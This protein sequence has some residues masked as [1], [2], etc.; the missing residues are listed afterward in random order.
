[1]P[2][3]TL[4]SS[5]GDGAHGVGMASV[6]DGWYRV[7]AT[8]T[9]RSGA[10]LPAGEIRLG[11]RPDTT[12]TTGTVFAW[13]A[14]FER[15]DPSA[16]GDTPAPSAY[17]PNG[18]PVVALS[19]TPVRRL[20]IYPTPTLNTD[21][22]FIVDYRA[23]WLPIVA[24]TDMIPVPSWADALLLE[25]CRAAARGAYEE[26]DAFTFERYA[27]LCASPTFQKYTEYDQGQQRS[28]G[29]MR[30][31]LDGYVGRDWRTGAHV[32]GP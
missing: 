25:F 20:A 2:V 8:I 31:I 5:Q 23:S 9:L 1:M 28:Y 27:A 3:V 17:S 7:W 18:G 12:G 26:D 32:T 4:L 30:T 14:Q 21:S 15:F 10:D 19:G 24:D 6:G 11:I 29:P 16:T 13:G 22:A